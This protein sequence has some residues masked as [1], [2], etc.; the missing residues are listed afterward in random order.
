MKKLNDLWVHQ[1]KKIKVVKRQ[2][3]THNSRN[4]K[5]FADG[6]RYESEGGQ[7]RVVRERPQM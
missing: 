1:V 3:I 6:G 4:R 7:G 5:A 2:I